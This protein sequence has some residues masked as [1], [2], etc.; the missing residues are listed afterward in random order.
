MHRNQPHACSFSAARQFRCIDGAIVPAEPHLQRHRHLHRGDCGL[1]QSDGVI[2]IAHQRRAGL[3]A[4]HVACRTTHI[5]ID[6]FS[7]RRFR[8]AGAFGHPPDLTARELNNVRAYS[9]GLAAQPRHGSSVDEIVAG[10]HFRDDQSGPQRCGQASKGGIRDTR[11]W[12]KKNPVSEL[13]I[14]YFQWLKA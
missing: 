9:G 11:H 14:A 4:R 3:A 6:N 7:T 5:D 12:R 8:D 1:D 2:K 10:S 13:N